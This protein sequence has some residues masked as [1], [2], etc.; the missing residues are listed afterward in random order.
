MAIYHN[1]HIIPKHMGG[2]DDPN[3]L[4]KLSVED[5]AEAHRLLYE[6]YGKKED[7]LAWKGLLGILSKE[8]IVEELI[9]IAAKKGN[10]IAN[11]NGASLKGNK[12]RNDRYHNDPD[13]AAEIRR[14]QSKPKS[15]TENYHKP[16]SDTHRKNISDSCL[17]KQRVACNCCGKLITKANLLKHQTACIRNS[18]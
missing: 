8:E 15:S 13:W 3:N 10:K 17:K 5:H 18:Y 7:Y 9:L 6:Q 4:T 2:N 16:K 1:H 14:K 11:E 12:A